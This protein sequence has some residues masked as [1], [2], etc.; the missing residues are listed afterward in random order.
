MIVR[1]TGF[2]W[3]WMDRLSAPE[4]AA[5][6]RRLCA[7]QA[8]L[9][10]LRRSGPRLR[11][12]A[13]AVMAA[14][15]A[16]RP[17]P[18]GHAEA[19]NQFAAWNEVAQQHMDAH[20]EFERLFE[21]GERSNREQVRKL[22]SDPRFAEAVAS[23]SPPVYLDIER[24]RFNN[25]LERQLASY[26]QRLCAKNETMSFFGPIHYGRVDPSAPDGVDARWQG[27]A[28]LRGRKAYAASWLVQGVWR[29]L[30]FEPDIAP[31][32][33][34]RRKGFSEAPARTARKAR[35]GD[36]LIRLGRTRPE[37]VVDAL[38]QQ[39][40]APSRKLGEL[41]LD[42]G[43]CELA[44]VEHALAVQSGR[45]KLPDAEVGDAADDLLPT[46]VKAADGAR[47]VAALAHD[48]GLELTA[49]ISHVKTACER[50]LLTHQLE[51]PAAAPHP[52]NDLIDRLCGI[53]GPGAQREVQRIARLLSLMARYG[54]ADAGQ[55]VRLNDEMAAYAAEQWEVRPP[56]APAVVSAREQEA[57]N[58][59]GEGHNFYADRLPI[60]E[61]CG[62]DL[63]VV[64]G[65][66]RAKEL[67]DRCA[68]ALELMAVAA[69]RTRLASQRALAA[70][71]G[72]RR[73][74]FWKVVAA[75]SDRPVEFDS[76]VRDALAAAITDPSA[77]SVDVAGKVVVPQAPACE[78]PLITSVDLLVGAKDAQ[79]WS[80]GDYELVMG[81]VHDTALVWGWALQFHEERARVET[82]L[83]ATMG[84]LHRPLPA[85]TMLASRRTGLLP[86]E[87]PGPVVEVGGVSARAS[88]WRLPFDDLIVEGDGQQVRL[89]STRLR[90]EVCLYNGELESLAHT[91]FALPRIRPLRVELG[92]HTPR[93][94]VNGAII[95][96]EQWVLEG[97]EVE[98]LLEARDDRSR[99]R[100]ATALWLRRGLPRQVFAKFAGERKPVLVDVESM[101]A[102]RVFL[103]LLEQKRQVVLSEVF[104]GPGTLWLDGPLGHH[105]SELR[106]T[107]FREGAR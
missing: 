25:R 12:P 69:V 3:E 17:I 2:P 73:L 7:L 28:V 19:P 16:G 62:G 65:G 26:L 35:L 71:V 23:S 99:F 54:E 98:L 85:V 4:A 59:R 47:N 86:A 49:M 48:L 68:P 92:A 36:I 27:P 38:K 51:I 79:A 33:V 29:K 45:A 96:R 22:A 64:V 9:D 103:N 82:D 83:L 81:D 58:R 107:F 88:A 10:E 18:E 95:Q 80:R 13:R 60:R 44:D 31:W 32:L 67:M 105:S 56:Q 89:W 24:G 34:L 53:P 77:R 93:I 41:L 84:A 50:G 66:A 40:T 61:E 74:P 15:V 1:T 87:L 104:P 46:L 102:L 37:H 52:L 70:L 20:A 39:L 11:R 100:V 30:A 106:C 97:A 101:P 91:A 5:V 78:L 14:L 63:R 21:L 6:A 8:R 75:F 90:S 76:A 72:T 57:K 94:L 55:K 42:A 43:A